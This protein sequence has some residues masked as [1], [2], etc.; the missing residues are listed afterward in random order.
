MHTPPRVIQLINPVHWSLRAKL[1][2]AVVVPALVIIVVALAANVVFLRYN[3]TVTTTIATTVAFLLVVIAIAGLLICAALGLLLYFTLW[4]PF[5]A[6][7]SGIERAA[8]ANFSQPIRIG[9]QTDELSSVSLTMNRLSA[10]LE[11]NFTDLEQSIAQRTRELETARDI[12]TALATIHDVNSIA[13]YI[14]TLITERFPPI[15]HTQ[16]FLNDS[17]RIVAVLV[18][19]TGEVGRQLLQRGHQLEIG[20]RSIIG[21]VTA[22]GE[23][24]V[25]LDTQRDSVHKPNELLKDTRSELA[26]PIRTREGVIGALDLQSRQPNAFAESEIKLFQSIAD[27]LGIAIEN[28]RL[29]EASQDRLRQ[30]EELNS[31]LL[32]ET[33][34]NYGRSRVRRGAASLVADERALSPLQQEAIRARSLI[35]QVGA[36]NVTL[37]VPIMLRGEPIGAVEWVIRRI[38]YTESTRVLATELV[39]RLAIAADNVRLI[40]SSQQIAQRE[41]VLNNITGTI[42]QQTDMARILQAAVRELGQ[43]LPSTRTRIQLTGDS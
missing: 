15:Y 27:Q 13:N 29:L 35:E 16:V 11:R 2:L 6:L 25:A 10:E 23:A 38:D 17:R 28:A 8:N 24:I 4:L 22:H 7:R 1:T 31:L 18:A 30:I 9:R 20:S 12:G 40:E 36:D 21:Q 3:P 34:Q 19:S 39:D 14:V 41:R 42:T 43:A 37:A 5:Q 26:L 32:L 33:W